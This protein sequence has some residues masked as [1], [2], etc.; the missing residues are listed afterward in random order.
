ML[1]GGGGG[2]TG[3]VAVLRGVFLDDDV[4]VI[5]LIQKIVDYSQ[6]SFFTALLP[7]LHLLHQKSRQ[8]FLHEKTC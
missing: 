1:R 5:L 4:A 3:G 2:G 6:A 8:P 7:K